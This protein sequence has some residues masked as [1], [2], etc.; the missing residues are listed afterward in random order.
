[1]ENLF[2]DG[3]DGDVTSVSGK[4][5]GKTRRREAEVGGVGGCPLCFV[6]GG[7]MRRRPGEG[8]GFSGEGSVERSHGSS[9]MRQ[10]PMVVVKHADELLQGLH[11]GGCR[12][13]T[14]SGNVFL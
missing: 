2:E 4:D 8:L 11:G 5:E 3:I 13:G 10:K 1:M 6:E 14:N 9:N 12:K 7:S